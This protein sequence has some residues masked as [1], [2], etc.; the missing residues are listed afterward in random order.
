MS[1]TFAQWLTDSRT[2]TL[3][4]VFAAAV[5]ATRVP[6]ALWVPGAVLVL[7]S[8]VPSQVTPLSALLVAAAAIVGLTIEA[9]GPWPALIVATCLLVPQYLLGRVLARGASPNLSFQL[10]SVAALAI[11]VLIYLVLADPAGVWRS[12]K[13]EIMP[14]L[15]RVADMMDNAGSGHRLDDSQIVEESFARAWGLVTWLLLLNTM[16]SVL[17]G[18][19]WARGKGYEPVGGASFSSLSAGR[20]LAYG[21][22]LTAACVVV[23][24]S[25]RLPT[26]AL[27]VFFGVFMLQ[28]LSILHSA[29]L[30]MGFGGVSLGLGY[31]AGFLVFL[32]AALAV[33]ALSWLVQCLLV[34]SGLIDNWLPLRDGLRAL[35]VRRRPS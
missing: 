16:V 18:V 21:G 24:S 14:T 32:L 12:V 30:A 34:V 22:L 17:F 28:G 19:Y 8:L 1:R 35:L 2:T 11:L 20:T 23:F 3:V 7:V 13:E 26:D 15:N 31:A 4:C 25:W 27:L 10:T 6:F 33:P 9:V 29:M 5:L